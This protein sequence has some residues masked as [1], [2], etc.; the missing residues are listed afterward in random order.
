MQRPYG[1]NADE[2]IGA[3]GTAEVGP[4]AGAPVI[5]EADG[6]NPILET[7]RLTHDGV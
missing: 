3:H 7:F 4:T 2:V 1:S 5:D 6:A